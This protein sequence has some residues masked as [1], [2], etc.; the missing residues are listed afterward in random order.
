MFDSLTTSFPERLH[1]LVA[2]RK[3]SIVVNEEILW[4]NAPLLA[5]KGV[6]Y[7]PLAASHNNKIF[8]LVQRGSPL[9]KRFFQYAS[10]T[11]RNY[12]DRKCDTALLV[13]QINL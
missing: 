7:F 5:S 10:C 9:A 8:A 2:G 11:D 1:A 12:S 4:F 3:S 13:I 6:H